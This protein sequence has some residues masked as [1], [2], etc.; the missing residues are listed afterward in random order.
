MLARAQ[1]DAGRGGR[2]VLGGRRGDGGTAR[3]PQGG[4]PE[5]D[6]ASRS[7]PLPAATLAQGK[8]SF[9]SD[10]PKLPAR[11]VLAR[12]YLIKYKSARNRINNNNRSE[13]EEVLKRTEKLLQPHFLNSD[14]S[15]EP[16]TPAP[17]KP[18]T[19][20]RRF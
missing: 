8:V 14:N 19:L 4:R 7:A 5:G 2:A 12:S 20:N 1:G 15:S 3:A 11:A 9:G 6:G 16:A 18:P 13:S 10:S 17:Y